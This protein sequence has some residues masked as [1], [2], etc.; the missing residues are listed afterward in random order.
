MRQAGRYMSEYRALRERYSLL[1]SAARPIWRP[2]SRCSRSGASR[3]TRRS[4]SPICCCR[5]SRWASASISS[6]AKGRRSRTRCAAKP[7][8]AR[9]RRFEPRE[10][11]AHVLDAIRQIKRGARRPR[12][13]DRLRRRAV[14][15]RVVRDRRRPLERLRAHQGA[16]V[17][18]TRRRGIGSATLLADVIGDYLVAQIEAGVDAVQVFDSWVG[19]LNAR[20]LSR[21]HP[22]AHAADL[23]RACAPSTR[24]ADDSFRRRHR[25]DPR[26]AARGRRRRDRRRLAHAARRGVGAHRLRPRASR[27]ISIR[28]CCSA[29]STASSPPP[30][31]CWSARADGPATSSISVTASC[32]STPVE[33]VQALARYVHQKTRRETL[34]RDVRACGATRESCV[35]VI[36]GA[37]ASLDQH[38]S[39]RDDRCS[40]DG[41]R[42]ARRRSTRCRNI[43]GWCAAGGRHQPSSSP[44]CATTT[45]RSAD[46]RR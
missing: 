7:T 20:R 10:A 29:R 38:L 24:R 33:H 18:R 42:H 37:D 43:C 15:A 36:S 16:D 26:R 28:R 22:A 4:C 2:K 3:W 40:V 30:T 35:V 11:L 46:A 25:R 8:S 39:I 6:T 32:R 45:R 23:R 21:V 12:A 27:A 41:P 31:R 5:S 1:E 14:H 34:G 44:R 13:A 19:A 9:V 17:R